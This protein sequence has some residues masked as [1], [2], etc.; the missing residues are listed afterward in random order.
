MFA[1]MEESGV[2]QRNGNNQKRGILRSNYTIISHQRLFLHFQYLSD[3]GHNHTYE[4]YTFISN[5]KVPSVKVATGYFT[6]I[7]GIVAI[8]APP[9][10]KA[11]F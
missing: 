3:Q 8:R 10:N 5:Y 2:K 4:Q 1:F 7:K 6:D 9:T 11:S